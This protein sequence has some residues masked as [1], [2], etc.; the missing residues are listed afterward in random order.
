MSRAPREH[1]SNS[2]ADRAG[3]AFRAWNALPNGERYMTTGMRGFSEA[4]RVIVAYRDM[5]AYPMTKVTMG[6]R[7]MVKTAT[8]DDTLR[9]GQRF[10]RLDRILTKLIRHPHMRLS[11]MEDIGGCRVI[12]DDLP[13]AYAVANRIMGRWG[14]TAHL[15]DY[16]EEPKDD[17]YRGIHIVERRDGRL[18]EVQLRTP[19][20]HAWAQSIEDYSPV[21]GFNLKDGE[22]PDDLRLYFKMAA[23]RIAQDELGEPQNPAAEYEFARLRTQVR[24]YF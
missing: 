14:K 3:D 4:V 17:G 24:K 15:T 1:V 20:Q 16:V 23:D 8:R 10:K 21:T 18:I 12:L 11:Q 6:V 7:S 19:G 22:G 9:P 13:Q 5:H 2:A